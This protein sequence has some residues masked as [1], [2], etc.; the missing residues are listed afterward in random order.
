MMI[1][2]LA[3][4]AAAVYLLVFGSWVAWRAGSWKQFPADFLVPA[5]CMLYAAAMVTVVAWHPWHHAPRVPFT[6]AVRCV[7]IESESNVMLPRGCQ[8]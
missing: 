7:A 4:A 5:G 3:V 8:R 6:P 1:A 2:V